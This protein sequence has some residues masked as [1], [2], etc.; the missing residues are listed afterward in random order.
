MSYDPASGFPR[1]V[2]AVRY[3]DV[4]LAVDWLSRVFGFREVLRRAGDDGRINHADLELQGGLVMLEP[5][6]E[7]SAGTAVGVA[8]RT[9][10]VVWVDDVDLHH[11]RATAEG[12]VIAFAPEDKQWGLRRYRAI[13]L[14]GHL[15]E[16]N[17]HIRDV[18]P[19]DWGAVATNRAS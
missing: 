19:E 12:A 11:R 14:E 17:Q 16:F 8:S 15:W 5:A 1:V 9:M 10:I 6:A 3:R 13:D 7:S 2:P 4:N 18:G